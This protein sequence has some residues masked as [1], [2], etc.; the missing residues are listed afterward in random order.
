MVPAM[1]R[2]LLVIFT[3]I[4]LVVIYFALFGEKGVV[5]ILRLRHEHDTI[6]ADVVR[7]EKQNEELSKEVRRLRE[8]PRYLETVARR[9]LGL[10]KE[11]ELLFIFEEEGVEKTWDQD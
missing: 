4:I 7:I 9:E 10:I 3:G 8:D 1:K 2:S 5:Q 6:M 11:N